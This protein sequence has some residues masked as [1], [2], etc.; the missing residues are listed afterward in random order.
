MSRKAKNVFKQHKSILV[1]GSKSSRKDI[2]AASL[3]SG[4]QHDQCLVLADPADWKYV[5]LGDV[6]VVIVEDFAGKYR[7]DLALCVK[8]LKTFDLI[9]ASVKGRKLNVIITSYKKYMDRCKTELGSHALLERIIELRDDDIG[10]KI[11]KTKASHALPS[12]SNH[13]S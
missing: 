11:I 7:Y 4:Y 3:V 2:F 9:Y 1:T 13:G 12:V 6:S 10:M 8:W 5:K